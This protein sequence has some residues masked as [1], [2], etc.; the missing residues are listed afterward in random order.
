MIIHHIELSHTSPHITGG[1]KALVEIVRYLNRFNNIS[2]IIYT[3][4]SGKDVY[5]EHLGEIANNIKFIVIGNKN[6]EKINEYLA[7][8]LRVFQ[9]FSKKIKFFNNKKNI[10]FSHEEFLP[11]IIY[12]WM[13]KRNNPTAKWIA[14]FHM[15]CP[16]IWSG[17][18][19]EY[20][21]KFKIPSARVI[22]YKFEQWIFFRLT[23]N[24]VNKIVTVNSCYSDFLNK[25]FRKSRSLGICD[26]D[27]I[28]AIKNYSGVDVPGNDV[29]KFYIEFDLCFMARFHEQKGVFELLDILKRLKKY[30]PDI[31][32]AL[33]GGGVKRVESKFFKLIRDNGLEK[34][35]KYFGYITGDKKFDIL[36]KSK[37]FIFPSYYESFGQVILEAMKCGLP[38]I[39]YNIPP[40]HIFKKGMIKI[41][42]LNNAEAVKEIVKLLEDDPYYKR[43]KNEAIE[44][45]SNFSWDKTGE[46][47]YN[48]IINLNI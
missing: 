31:L 47:I 27:S 6:I 14:F 1:E 36:K 17:F 22:R 32:L 25:T 4:E 39:A 5:C 35:I 7:Y 33:I 19:G 20:T 11:T 48:L 9:V 18:E 8:Y 15:K 44:F 43:I 21:G 42:T 38:V 28:Y 40:F 37:I 46:E 10:I 2:Q 24:N 13:M 30:K 41:Q 34:N 45:S 3:S 23:M 26:E 16:S 29:E 12:S